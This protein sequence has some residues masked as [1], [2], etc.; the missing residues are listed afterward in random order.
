MSVSTPIG[1]PRH[2]LACVALIFC[3]IL[4][5]WAIH[6]KNMLIAEKIFARNE[7]F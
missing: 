2:Q 1:R 5:C 4:T 7:N 3:R 6:L